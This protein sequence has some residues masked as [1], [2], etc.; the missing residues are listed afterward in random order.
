MKSLTIAGV[1]LRRFVRDRGNLFFVFIFPMLLILVLGSAFGG[2]VNPRLGV[3]AGGAGPL[4]DDLVDRLEAAESVE[5]IR[6]GALDSM[7]QGVERGE[8]EAAVVIPEDYDA[9]VRSGTPV[10]VEFLA[11]DAQETSN[12]RGIVESAITEQS[13]VLRAARF[14]D[15]EGVAGFGDALIVAEQAAANLGAVDVTVTAAGEAFALDALG[16]FDATAQ[17]QLILFMFVTS[18]AGSSAL[19][20]TRRLGVARRMISTPTTVRAVLVGEGL[21]RYAVALVQG[22]FILLGTWIIFSV[23]WGDPLLAILILLI[24]GLVGSGAAM[25]M[26][27]LFS[28][29]EQAGGMGVL[30]GLGLAALGGCMMPLQVFELISPGLYN[31]AHITPHAWA[32][33]AFDSITIDGGTLID[34]LPFLV[35]LLAYAAVFYGLAIWRLRVVLTR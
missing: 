21:G 25:L 10:D 33:E 30:L 29:D 1:N 18:L 9:A 5:V 32:L 4:G 3:F 20:Q 16:Q 15:G 27:A 7:Q 17:T 11:R 14:V 23:D 12:L 31:V 2:S 35:I 28:N 19:I 26:G 13:V 34:I 24:F 8:L 22:I 6:A